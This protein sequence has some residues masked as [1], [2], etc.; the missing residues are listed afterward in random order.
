MSYFYHEAAE[1]E[2]SL[3]T[4]SDKESHHLIHVLRKKNGDRLLILNGRG[5]C[6]EGELTGE[7]AKRANVFIHQCIKEAEKPSVRFHLSVGPTKH[8]DRME[9]LTEKATELGVWSI[10]PV[11]MQHSERKTL[12]TDKLQQ[13]AIAAIK[14][15]GNLFLP[16]I[17]EPVRFEEWLSQT[18]EFPFRFVGLQHAAT[19]PATDTGWRKGDIHVL[20]GPEGGF[21]PSEESRMREEKVIPIGVSPN[22]LRVETAALTL[23]AQFQYLDSTPEIQH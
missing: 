10:R 18:K 6:F 13:V 8:A 2:N 15:S 12:R 21:S 11:F 7:N 3:I 17:Y 14:Q 4:L 19:W 23:L 20:V 9:W 5:K 1:S 22:R 16:H